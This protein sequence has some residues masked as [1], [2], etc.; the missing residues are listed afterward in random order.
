ME[1]VLLVFYYLMRERVQLTSIEHTLPNYIGR[2]RFAGQIGQEDSGED[3]G[4]RV[5]L[6]ATT[7]SRYIRFV[8]T[9]MGVAEQTG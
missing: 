9:F 2:P 6:T 5:S 1:L 7:P 3:S 8:F 4:V